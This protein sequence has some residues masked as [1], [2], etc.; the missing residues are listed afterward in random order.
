M[1]LIY[2]HSFEERNLKNILEGNN[3]LIKSKRRFAMKVFVTAPGENR[4]LI[5]FNCIHQQGYSPW[6][7]SEK[8]FQRVA[9]V[10]GIA[11]SEVCDTWC[12]N[13]AQLWQDVT[14]V[15]FGGYV[16]EKPRGGRV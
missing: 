15:E 3:S 7:W 16:Y 11:V 14:S 4:A 2:C 9:E 8:E 13:L 12:N 10:E 5:N 6:S 1:F